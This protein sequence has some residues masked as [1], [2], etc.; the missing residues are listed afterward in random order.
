MASDRDK[1]RE[2]NKTTTK[3]N[4]NKSMWVKEIVERKIEEKRRRC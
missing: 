3:H 2:K 4:K 1:D